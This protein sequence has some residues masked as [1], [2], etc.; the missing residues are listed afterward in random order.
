[1]ATQ[2]TYLYGDTANAVLNTA[3][4]RVNDLIL[5][6]PGSP[7]GSDP[8]QQLTQVGG[9]TLLA[10]TNPDGSLCLRTQIIFNS[11]WRKFQKDL[12]NLGYRLLIGDNLIIPSLPVNVNPDPA[13]QSWL[14]WNGFFDGTN[15]T[16]V[17]SLPAN[18]LAPLKIRERQSGTNSLFI[19]MLCSLDGLR[20]QFV[21][22]VLNRQWEWRQN[23]LYLPGA[24][25]LT[26]LQLRY[27]TFFPDLTETTVGSATIPWYYQTL[28]VPRCLSA[29]AWYVAIE[30]VFP[31]GDEQGYSEAR[32]EAMG[33]MELVFNDQ[34]RADQRTNNRRR[35]RGGSSRS[36]GSR[37]GY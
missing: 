32:A 35:P 22:T 23:A 37:L 14:S 8:G 3:R 18:F 21:R 30:V 27:I 13:A 12:G 20:G 29:L 7:T 9:G 31:R 15:F 11:A 24:T 19:P 26:D 4:S 17:P 34:A 25:S 36:R 33:E 28:P 16:T 5:T 1:M 10:E 2:P 6:P